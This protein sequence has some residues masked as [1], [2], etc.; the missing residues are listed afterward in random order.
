MKL[1]RSARSLLWMPLALAGTL[2]LAA[3]EVQ[4]QDAIYTPIPMPVTRELTDTLSEDDIP[5]EIGRASCR[6]RV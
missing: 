2:S 5:T 1:T 6:E 4:A 3:V